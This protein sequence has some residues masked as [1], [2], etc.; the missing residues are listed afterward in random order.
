MVKATFTS[1]KVVALFAAYL[2]PVLLLAQ[3]PERYTCDD[4]TIS[5]FSTTPLEDISANNQKVKS[6]LDIEKKTLAFV[7]TMKAFDFKKS[8]MQ[9]HFNE[10]YVESD[11]Y[12]QA[13][14]S[15]Q[16]TSAFNPLQFTE[17]AVTVEGEL[18]LHGITKYI[19][20]NGRL[21]PHQEHITGQAEFKVKLVDYDIKIP[22]IVIKNIAEEI[23]VSVHV[24]YQPH[25][26]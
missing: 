18:T 14:F 12:P 2:I 3:H 24:T 20:V 25:D 16:I 22:K 23:A 15:G 1:P 8:L 6:I 7:V 10:K 4:G 21:H 13:T 17:Q 5:F 11:T 26:N 19:T 9:E